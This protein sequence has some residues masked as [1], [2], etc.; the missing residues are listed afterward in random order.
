MINYE[1]CRYIQE[2]IYKESIT[3]PDNS[4]EHRFLIPTLTPMPN[5]TGYLIDKFKLANKNTSD[6]KIVH[7]LLND[8]NLITIPYDEDKFGELKEDD[9]FL[10][11]FIG[12]DL[13]RIRII[14]R[15]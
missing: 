12:G 1:P 14:G 7:H 4:I 15:I 8:T 3:N 13:T 6:I 9:T 10:I 2:A 11:A 5:T